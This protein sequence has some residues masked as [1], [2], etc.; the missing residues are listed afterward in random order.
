[1]VWMKPDLSYGRGLIRD[2][3]RTAMGVGGDRRTDEC[4]GQLAGDR[5][6]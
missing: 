2:P 4:W 3:G 6:R 1:M 5:D